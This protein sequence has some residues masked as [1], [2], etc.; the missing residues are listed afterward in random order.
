MAEQGPPGR[1]ARDIVELCKRR[2]AAE[3]PEVLVELAPALYAE[4]EGLREA[5]SDQVKAYHTARREAL[6]L[7]AA[8]AQVGNQ[9]DQLWKALTDQSATL[10]PYLEDLADADCACDHSVGLTCETCLA[11]IHLNVLRRVLAR[12]RKLPQVIQDWLDGNE[13]I[14]SA[15]PAPQDGD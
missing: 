3:G 15:T 8:N 14:A 6:V 7:E 11:R 10:A 9:L 4:I 1:Y 12:R 2:H 5:V 13:A